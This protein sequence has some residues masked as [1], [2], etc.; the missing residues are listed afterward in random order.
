MDDREQTEISSTSSSTED[1]GVA[2]FS[3][4]CKCIS[5]S[6][7]SFLE[8]KLLPAFTHCLYEERKQKKKTKQRYKMKH[9]SVHVLKGN[10]E[11]Q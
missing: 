11:S 5:S 3:A 6:K 8:V 1:K 10:N 7:A 9:T 2:L 4:V